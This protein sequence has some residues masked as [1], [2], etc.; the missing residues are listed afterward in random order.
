MI[1]KRLGEYASDQIS[2]GGTLKLYDLESKDT[3]ELTFDK[4]MTGLRLWLENERPF[5][6]MNG[7]RLDIGNIDA[8]A[9][10]SIVQ[11]ALFNDIVFG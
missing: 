3:W 11:Y 4:F 10:D 1:G 7:V 6:I 8:V 9:A 2:R 5:T